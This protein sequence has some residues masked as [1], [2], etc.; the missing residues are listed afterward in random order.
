[1]GE[2]EDARGVRSLS[3]RGLGL[4][5]EGRNVLDG[6]D[7]AIE[8]GAIACIEGPSGCGKSTLLRV[9]ATLLEPTA[10]EVYLE[11]VAAH[12]IAPRTFRRRVAYVPQQAPMLEGTVADNVAAGPRLR[13][14]Q[15]T[16]TRVEQC[17]ALVGLDGA[18]AARPASEL[19]GGERQR[20]ALARALANEP[21]FLLLDEP[22]AALDTRAAERILERV[23]ALAREG[24]GLVVVT[25]E[26]THAAALGARRRTMHAGR[27]REGEG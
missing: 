16:P 3:A 25:H 8:A 15:P 5:R 2:S 24:L 19:S 18:F 14:A 6:V 20:V 11:G 4:A 1:M 23:R 12:A 17:L 9:L 26:P 22:T 13:G 27:L 7:F 21:E 10:G